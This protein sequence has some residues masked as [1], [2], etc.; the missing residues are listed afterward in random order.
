MRARLALPLHRP[1]IDGTGSPQT[2]VSVSFL[3]GLVAGAA[4][5]RVTFDVEYE[6]LIADPDASRTAAYLRL[7][8][9]RD[10]SA[11]LGAFYRRR[12]AQ[13]VPVVAITVRLPESLGL[14]VP[15]PRPAGGGVNDVVLDALAGADTIDL[16][17]YAYTLRSADGSAVS[18]PK[19]LYA[20][21]SALRGHS[22]A[23]DTFLSGFS[24]DGF[25]ESKLVDLDA[26]DLEIDETFDEYDYMSD[27]DL[28]NDDRVG[29]DTKGKGRASSVD[30]GS[31]NARMGR[32]IVFELEDL[33]KRAMAAI[34]SRLSAGNIVAETFSHF[35]SLY[36]EI[37]D[38]HVDALHQNLP[39]VRDEMR[40]ALRDLCSE[41]RPHCFEVLEKIVFEASR[42]VQEEHGHRDSAGSPDR[43]SRRRMHARD[44][45]RERSPWGRHSDDQGFAYPRE[46]LFWPLAIILVQLVLLGFLFGLFAHVHKQ[47]RVFLPYGPA[48]FVLENTQAATCVVTFLATVFAMMSGY[49]LSRAI[50]LAIV[51]HMAEKA[52][53]IS[54]FQY[55]IKM[56]SKSLILSP[57]DWK[58]AV[59]AG[60]LFLATIEQTASWNTLFTPKSIAF[61]VHVSGAE[62]DLTNPELLSHA[63]DLYAGSIQG[64]LNGTLRAIM[65]QAGTSSALAA[66]G[67]QTT[68]NYA[69]SAFAATTGGIQ[70]INFVLHYNGQPIWPAASAFYPEYFD[71]QNTENFPPLYTDYNV[72]MTQQGLTAAVS[73]AQRALSAT[74]APAITTAQTPALITAGNRTSSLTEYEIVI[75]CAGSSAN[76]SIVVYGF[77]IYAPMGPIVC[78][79]APAIYDAQVVHGPGAIAHTFDANQ[80]PTAIDANLTLGLLDG[81]AMLFGLGQSETG[82][83]IGDA[84]ISTQNDQAAASNQTYVQLWEAY[85][86]GTIE[87]LATAIKLDVAFPGTGGAFLHGLPKSMSRKTNG[88]ATVATVGYEYTAGSAALLL[89]SILIAVLSILVSAYALH[90]GRRV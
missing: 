48:A 84:L 70:P 82:N 53:R 86:G 28:E 8:C 72:T 44:A 21:M 87:F 41:H 78:D 6:N 37:Q 38:L 45:S 26:R 63:V 16:K 7:P 15:Q 25:S 57:R 90:K 88:T 46:L 4:Y 89:P 58:W 40:E 43:F 77:G 11:A 33:K 17:F 12:E 83:V 47:G 27:S 81:L 29:V 62:V 73:C 51:V 19:P 30:E 23:L 1:A 79:I 34:Q 32:V 74:T 68:L 80:A 54:E 65:N 5:G 24:G 55:M 64:Y 59:C 60:V 13:D 76:G 67:Y 66:S 31:K 20:K 39:Q 18:R 61:Q 75:G 52:V 10:S 36:P 71:T 56:A 69:G 50:R 3:P 2:R 9:S 42:S 14:Q 22:V 49:L 85:L 35:T